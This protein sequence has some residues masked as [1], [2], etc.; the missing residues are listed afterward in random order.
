MEVAMQSQLHTRE[1]ILSLFSLVLSNRK[2]VRELMCW[3]QDC[4]SVMDYFCGD[5]KNWAVMGWDKRYGPN[6]V[7]W[8]NKCDACVFYYTFQRMPAIKVR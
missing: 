6:H 3:P 4:T 8:F 1:F 7:A 5:T 2:P